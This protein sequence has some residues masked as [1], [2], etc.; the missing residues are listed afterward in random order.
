MTYLLDTC[1]VSHFFKKQEGVIQKLQKTSPAQIFIS[2]LTVHEIEYGL[3]LK[4][5]LRKKI[6]EIWELFLKQINIIPFDSE[7]AFDAAK[8]RAHLKEK[9]KPIGAYDLLIGATALSHDKIIVTDNVKEF[10]R[11][12]GLEIENW[13]SFS[14]AYFG[15]NER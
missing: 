5:A 10:E 14:G 8:I 2:S 3:L 12:Q 15:K 11:I 9:G 13:L 1:I 7:E 4:P 6:G